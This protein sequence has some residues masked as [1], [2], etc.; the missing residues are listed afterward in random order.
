MSVQAAEFVELVDVGVGTGAFHYPEQF[1][2]DALG[3]GRGERDCPAPARRPPRRPGSRARAR[4]GSRVAGGAGR[5]RASPRSPGASAAARCRDRRRRCRRVAE[6][7]GEDFDREGVGGEVAAQDVGLDCAVA[8]A[9]EVESQSA[10]GT[11]PAPRRQAR[12]GPRA[13]RG[14]CGRTGRRTRGR[15]RT[16]RSR[17]RSARVRAGCREWSRRRGTAARPDFSSSSRSYVRPMPR[18]VASTLSFT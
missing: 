7:V 12:T 14:P 8:E 13:C 6:A 9:V 15:S 11:R 10:G 4:C 18:S 5:V 2:A 17:S 1:R 3:R 16:P